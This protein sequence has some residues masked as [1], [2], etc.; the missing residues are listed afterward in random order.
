MNNEQRLQEVE[1]AKAKFGKVLR[2]EIPVSRQE[3]ESDILVFLNVCTAMRQQD[4]NDAIDERLRNPIKL[5]V[6]K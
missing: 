2:C 5:R 1:A 3:P 6:I 4:T